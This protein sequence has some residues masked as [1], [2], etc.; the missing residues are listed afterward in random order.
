MVRQKACHC[1][2]ARNREARLMTLLLDRARKRLTDGRGRLFVAGERRWAETGSEAAGTAGP[3]GRAPEAVTPEAAVSWLQ[4]E[5]GQP[6]KA[7]VGVVGPRSATARQLATAE[8]LG[9]GLAGL[10]LTVIC[11]G[12]GGVMEAVCRGVAGAGGLS[13]GLL[14]DDC[15]TAANIHVSVPLAT[16]LGVARNAVIARAAVC[17]LA[18]G[19]GYGTI[20]EM[21]FALQFGR[22]VIGL[23]DAPDLPGVARLGSVEAALRALCERLLA[24]D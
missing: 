21:A 24:L 18:V 5:S 3:D 16:G 22:P 10:G 2:H 9:A 12:R 20:S 13:I 8:A 6:L 23:D 7:P 19:G 4:R 15:W 1:N 11:G 17:L 14:P